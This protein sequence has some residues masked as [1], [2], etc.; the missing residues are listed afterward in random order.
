M[1]YRMAGYEQRMRM[2]RMS[3]GKSQTRYQSHDHSEK[4]SLLVK[5]PE[6]QM[7][8]HCFLH[9]YIHISQTE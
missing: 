6:L 3:K 9:T 8:I 5:N 7:M 1:R 4:S 2:M